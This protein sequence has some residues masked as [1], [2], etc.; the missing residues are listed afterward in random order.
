MEPR[1]T[2]IRLPNWSMNQYKKDWSE[3]RKKQLKNM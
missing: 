1:H 2:E 3:K